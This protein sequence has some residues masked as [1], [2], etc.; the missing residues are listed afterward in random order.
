MDEWNGR[1]MESGV[2]K[3]RGMVQLALSDCKKSNLSRTGNTFLKYDKEPVSSEY[4]E[5]PI[6]KSFNEI[7]AEVKLTYNADFKDLVHGEFPDKKEIA[8]QFKEIIKIQR[9]CPF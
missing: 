9:H 5:S 7:W 6:F 1:L 4:L 8:E 2:S 3:C